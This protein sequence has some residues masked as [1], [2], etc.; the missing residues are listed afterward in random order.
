MADDSDEGE[1][2][3]RRAFDLSELTGFGEDYFSASDR[4][5]REYE[6][7]NPSLSAIT[8]AFEV[9]G[10]GSLSSVMDAAGMN[11]A[12]QAL[13]LGKTGEIGQIMDDLTGTKALAEATRSLQMPSVGILADLTK[14]LDLVGFNAAAQRILD[15]DSMVGSTFSRLTQDL[16]TGIAVQAMRA[17][18]MPGLQNI[19]GTLNTGGIGRA[20]AD[21]NLALGVGLPATFGQ[22]LQSAVGG[23]ANHM[24][25]MGEIGRAHQ[26][27]F[28]SFR[29]TNLE[30]LLA[31][32]LAV[33]EALLEEQQQAT[34]DA[35]AEAK[36]NRRLA[37]VLAVIN[38][39]MLLMSMVGTIEDWMT[40]EDAATKANTAAIVEMRDAFDAMASEMEAMRATQEAEAERQSEA[41]AEIAGILRD[42]A[43]ALADRTETDE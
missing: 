7:L 15:T 18:E 40:D 12:Q 4:L 19:L 6:K 11:A 5:A 41:D 26:A 16:Q 34:L 28:E 30:T 3:G 43:D 33:H 36:F 27:A 29:L 21:A 32:S 22:D 23:L 17:M 25:A 2:E 39:I 20:I 37:V 10:L 42:I 1:G 13:G 14:S 8:K 9:S 31:K 38:I 35:K 24:G